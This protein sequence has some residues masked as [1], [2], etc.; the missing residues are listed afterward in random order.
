MGS[1]M[2][3]KIEERGWPEG[4]GGRGVLEGTRLGKLH[5]RLSEVRDE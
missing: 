1:L 3:V 5:V 4:R 2:R